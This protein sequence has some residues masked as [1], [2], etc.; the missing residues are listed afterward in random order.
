MPFPEDFRKEHGRRRY[1]DRP[2]E[3][4]DETQT[5]PTSGGDTRQMPKTAKEKAQEDVDELI[6]KAA[7]REPYKSGIVM[8]VFGYVLSV[9]F[10]VFCV[11]IIAITFGYILWKYY[12]H[13]FQ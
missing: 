6:A 11:G 7:A 2:A 8:R 3:Q 1:P 9:M 12:S 5:I 4:E 13:L 10:A